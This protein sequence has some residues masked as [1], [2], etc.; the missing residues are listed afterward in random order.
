MSNVN[1]EVNDLISR[2]EEELR[3]MTRRALLAESQVAAI[4]KNQDEDEGEDHGDS[5]E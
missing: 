2:Y 3:V 5:D 1:I 4:K